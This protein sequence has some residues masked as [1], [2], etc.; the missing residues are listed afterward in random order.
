MTPS[1]DI[2]SKFWRF[3]D[4]LKSNPNTMYRSGMMPFITVLRKYKDYIEWNANRVNWI[5]KMNKA[6]PIELVMYIHKIEF[7]RKYRKVMNELIDID[8]SD[9]IFLT[10]SNKV[11]MIKNGR[12]SFSM[13]W[14]VDKHKNELDIVV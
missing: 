12:C 8:R 10:V 11:T 6:L 9:S 7:D 14:V 3:C 4:K 1:A 13:L 5:S 2:I